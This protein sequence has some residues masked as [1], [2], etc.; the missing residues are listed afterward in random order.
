M[1]ILAGLVGIVFL[2]W[3]LSS[4]PRSPLTSDQ[5]IAKYGDKL[6]PDSQKWIAQVKSERGAK[7]V[8]IALQTENRSRLE[9]QASLHSID[10][11]SRLISVIRSSN[12]SPESDVWAHGTA[13][14]LLESDIRLSNDYVTRLENAKASPDVWSIVHDD[15]IALS[16]QKILSNND[17]ALNQFYYKNREWFH[18][19]IDVLSETLTEESPSVAEDNNSSSNQGT[20]I[21]NT[22]TAAN[23]QPDLPTSLP[24]VPVDSVLA[25]GTEGLELLHNLIPRPSQDMNYAS[26]A[27]SIMAAHSKLLVELEEEGIPLKQS[28]EFAFINADYIQNRI[29]QDSLEVFSKKLVK[30][31]RDRP[32]VWQHA[33]QES[34]VVQLDIATPEYSSQ[35]LD[36]YPYYGVP[37]LLMT[38][39]PAEA[40]QSA[41]I[42]ERYGELGIAVLNQYAESERFHQLLQNPSLDK[43]IAMVAIME[44]DVGLEK[45][46]KDDRYLDKLVKEN[47]DPRDPDWWQNVPVVGSLAN[48]ARNYATNRPNDY[49]EIGWA[50]WDA[51][52]LAL[53]IGSLGTSKV[54]TEAGKQ[55][56]K[57]TARSAGRNAAKS[58]ARS[59]PARGKDL[60]KSNS[61][62]RN[63]AVRL[64]RSSLGRLTVYG[65]KMIYVSSVATTRS[66]AKI[67]T[68]IGKASKALAPYR[69]WIARGLLGASLMA[70]LPQQL[71]AIAQHA[72]Q[73]A[74]ETVE[75]VK[76]MLPQQILNAMSQ[77][78]ELAKQ[79]EL[80]SWVLPIIGGLLIFVAASN[81]IA[82]VF[83]LL[84]PIWLI[85]ST[86]KTT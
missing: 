25:I 10:V 29:A 26:L 39:Y 78:A 32:I 70:R 43:R 75:S 3:G 21:A 62:I 76:Q 80:W 28:I 1:R 12:Y 9:E 60:V 67:S 13:L 58:L 17:P 61:A 47:G 37:A 7:N 64:E 6:S 27:F 54:F 35:I 55:A 2:V 14:Q 71:A 63:L 52:D 74:K 4:I 41:A 38:Q 19:L 15:P 59:L 40:V 66:I 23:P 46:M 20:V 68:S 49:G 53:M 33:C 22:S 31:Y 51:A 84:F 77:F 24:L 5:V 85:R 45:L 57:S 79:W 82:Q 72:T 8:A 16:S 73:F 30:L 56:V 34:F 48:V 69:V 81:V 18:E 65:T 83:K 44:S 36:K 42:V 86:H 50:A 11:R